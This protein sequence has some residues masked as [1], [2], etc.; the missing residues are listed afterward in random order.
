MN[1]TEICIRKPVFAWML[2]AATVVFG[3]VAASRI[4]ISQYPDVDFP[5]ITVSADWEGASPEAIETEIIEP[6]EE[7][8]MQVEG[9]K[10]IT[11]SSRQ[12]RGSVTVEL[13][14]A[15]DVDLALQDV[16]SKVN[17]VNLPNDV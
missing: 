3:G 1:L 14:L 13:D 15:R 16:Q 9:V 17:R 5:T 7:A 10:S 12:G 6:I 11:S 8:C 2:M 4:G